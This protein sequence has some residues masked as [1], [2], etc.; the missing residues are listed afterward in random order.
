MLLQQ[1]LLEYIF[2]FGIIISFAALVLGIV[3]DRKNIRRV[4]SGSGFMA[5]DVAIVIGIVLVFVFIEM[6][7][8]KATQLLFFDDAI[9]Q[10]M[11]LMLMRTGQAWMCNFGT[12]SACFTGQIFHEPIGLSFNLAMAFAIF[13]VSRASAYGTQLALGVI[14]VAM[15]FFASLLLLKNKKA[16]FFTELL[17]ALSPV[18]IVWSKPTNSDLAVLAYSLISVFFFMVFLKKKTLWSFS[19]MLFSF[20]LLFYMKVDEVIFIPIFVAFYLL[21]DDRGIAKNISETLRSVKDN[22]FN[23]RL[24]LIILFFL[25]AVIPS[26]LYSYNESQV[27]TYG[28]QG[29][30]IQNTCTKNL[31][32]VNVT[33]PIN[34]RNFNTNVCA[35][36]EFWFNQYNS[37]YVMQPILFTVLAILGAALMLLIGKSRR[38]LAA[39]GIWFLVFFFLYTAFYA[40]SVIY[41][42]DWRFMLSLIAQSCMLGGFAL[43]E[44]LDLVE[45]H[46]R[47]LARFS[48][49]IKAIAVIAV[50]AILAAPIYHLLPL[51]SVNPATIQQAGDARFYENFVY[52]SSY[53]IPRNCLIYTYD[54]TLFQLQNLT[55]TQMDNLYNTTQTTQYMNE[56]KCLVLDYGYWCHT[57]NNE[58]S[59]APQ[60]YNL[61]PL[62]LINYTP[63]KYDFGFYYVYKKQQ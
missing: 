22:F 6:F 23:T 21:L 4:L 49:A 32:P 36:V 48:I 44:I 56:G 27:D 52:N 15:G 26:I 55:A 59:Y 53:L 5:R 38:I 25:I 3:M 37:D 43:A 9:Y 57:P 51:I 63:N 42:V 7:F 58:C 19:N 35:N 40:G 12:A 41:G 33:G 34:L 2:T 31:S 45:Y 13:G 24:L 10:A 50:L 61:V 62:K 30:V 46:A 39:I 54:P 14:S 47:K 29:T 16:A 8:V 18:I 60:S 20:S 1:G 28:W 11:A 17:L